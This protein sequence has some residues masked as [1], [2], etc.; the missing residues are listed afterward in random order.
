LIIYDLKC[1]NGH[2]FEGWFRDR[3]AF[4][5][6]KTQRLIACPVCGSSN[7]DLLPSFPVS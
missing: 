5:E 2:K 6:Q 1:E 4:E 7:S 3:K